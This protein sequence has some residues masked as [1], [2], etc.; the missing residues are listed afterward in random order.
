MDRQTKIEALK[1]VLAALKAIKHVIEWTE[2]RACELAKQGGPYNHA[3][4]YAMGNSASILG[5][6]EWL[7]TK[8][9]VFATWKHFSGSYEFPVPATG[10]A[11]TAREAYNLCPLGDY[12][13]LG[14]GYGRKRFE[15]LKHCIKEYRRMLKELS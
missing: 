8:D 9:R 13:D 2:G 5:L 4:C 7:R 3:L 15:L 1:D 10:D 11:V 6:R 12:F 14:T